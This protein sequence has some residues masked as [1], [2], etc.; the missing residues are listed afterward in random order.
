[1]L[2]LSGVPQCIGRVVGTARPLLVNKVLCK[3]RA[4]FIVLQLIVNI[5][6]LT[7]AVKCKSTKRGVKEVTK[8]LRKGEKG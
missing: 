2:S 3:F 8:A 4:K 5:F 1:M 7:V 6:C